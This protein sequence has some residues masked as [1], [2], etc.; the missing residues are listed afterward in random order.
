MGSIVTSIGEA[1]SKFFEKI[2]DFLPVLLLAAGIYLGYGYMT[3]FQSGGWPAIKSWGQSLMSGLSQGETISAATAAADVGTAGATAALPQATALPALGAV[4]TTQ[5]SPTDVT[6]TALTAAGVEGAPLAGEV[7]EVGQAVNWKDTIDGLIAQNDAMSNTWTNNLSDFNSGFQNVLNSLNPISD[8]Q[9]GL[10]LGSLFSRGTTEVTGEDFPGGQLVG[11][12]EFPTSTTA[13]ER[14][15][16]ADVSRADLTSAADMGGPH[17][18]D[19]LFP[20]K[21]AALGKK[22]WSI[23]K[24]MWADNPGMAMW[25]TSNVLKTILALLDDS[26][27]KESYARRHVMGFSPGGFDDMPAKY[28]GKRAAGVRGGG[29]A[30]ASRRPSSGLKVGRLPEASASRTS[31]IDRRPAGIIGSTPQRTV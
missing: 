24:N 22:A 8:A 17:F 3:G 12:R 27:E 14:A 21:L 2:K 16:G 25:T 5:I 11:T 26:A 1:I 10:P 20:P 19:P 29:T 23:Y 31:A 28:G 18:D 13:Y 4:D 15:M 7:A 30:I 9:A 6:T